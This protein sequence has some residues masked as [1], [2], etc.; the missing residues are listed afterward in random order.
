MVLSIC[1]KCLVDSVHVPVSDDVYGS[2]D[3]GHDDL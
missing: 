3:N 2:C 1:L